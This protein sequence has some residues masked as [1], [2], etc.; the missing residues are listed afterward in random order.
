M[1]LSI[2]F[3]RWRQWLQ[4]HSL[5]SSLVLACGLVTVAV[6]AY[7]IVSSYSPVPMG[8]EWGDIDAIAMA[9]NHQ[10]PLTWLWSQHNEH[11]IVA[12][13]LLLLADIHWF[14]GRHWIGFAAILAVQLGFLVLLAR[15]LRVAGPGGTVSRTIF[16]LGAFC[17]FC[18]TQWENFFWAIGISVLL[19]GFFLM[20]ALLCLVSYEKALR[21]SKSGSRYLLAAIAAAFAA[22]CSN[23]NGLLAW[24]VLIMVAVGLG[25]RA[26][27]V[28]I[29]AVCGFLAA[30]VYLCHYR[31]PAPHSSPI[32]SLQ[33]PILSLNYIVSYLGVVLPPWIRIRGP[34]AAISG[35]LGLTSAI[36]F[37]FW[38]LKRY[39][40]R[41]SFP[42][43]MIGLICFAVATAAITALG[44]LRFGVEQ[45]FQSRYQ[46]TNLLFWFGVVSLGLLLIE[47]KTPIIRNAA[48]ALVAIAMLFAILQ[49]GPTLRAPRLR[50]RRAEAAALSLVTGVPDGKILRFLEDNY[51]IGPWRDTPYLRDH[52]LFMFSGSLYDR[53]NEAL[54]PA[55]AI[56]PPEHCAGAVTAI[57]WVPL[58]DS[59]TGV[60]ANGL[61][62]FGWGVERP[63]GSHIR[64]LVITAD[65]RIVGYA[66]GGLQLN[67]SGNKIFLKQSEFTEWLGS[68]QPPARASSLDL[69]A[70]VSNEEGLCHLA[71]IPVPPKTRLADVNQAP[72]VEV[73]ASQAWQH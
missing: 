58:Q 29:F 65:D 55:H 62:I 36:L 12:Y 35:S 45:A 14:H 11:R 72:A 46:S 57:E 7:Q 60:D 33:H 18:P 70:S 39:P 13:R 28:A 50:T 20:L 73:G 51:P 25:F 42:W 21:N 8:D 38:I 59:L 24:P 15:L 22:T 43:T 31:S 17:L 5:L 2:T 47:N 9:P 40:G 34:L 56:G 6:G 44:R 69:Y 26:R 3:N 63:S 10:P 53:L 48:T 37:S 68:A 52:R 61:R 71:S 19:P 1:I 27:S 16:G 30:V 64:S 23:G 41:K 49:F 54:R 66:V 4:L 67:T 32:E